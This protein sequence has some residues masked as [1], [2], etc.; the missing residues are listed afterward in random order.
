MID[1]YLQIKKYKDFKTSKTS[2]LLVLIDSDFKEK[3]ELFTHGS[4]KN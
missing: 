3:N 4:D 2:I 1:Y